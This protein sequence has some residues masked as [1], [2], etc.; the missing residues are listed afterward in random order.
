MVAAGQQQCRVVNLVRMKG[1]TQPDRLL[2][3]R[4]AAAPSP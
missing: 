3:A 2:A 1:L 4:T